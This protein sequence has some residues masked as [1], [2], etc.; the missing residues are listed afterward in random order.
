MLSWFLR[1]R[2]DAFQARY[3][4]DVGYLRE[5]L[6]TSPRVL[7]RFFEAT[8]LG[9][10]RSGVPLE[11][12]TAVHLVGVLHEDCGP[13]VQLGVD[14]ALEAGVAPETLEAILANNLD[15][16]SDECALSV[17]YARAVLAREPYADEHRE[18]LLARYG[19]TGLLSLACALTS[20]RLYP[21]MKYALGFGTACHRV[22]VH[23]PRLTAQHGATVGVA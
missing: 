8:Q 10:V 13:C 5:I 21:T 20:A 14:M 3:D 4:Y 7:L 9:R 11:V 1:R 2:L 15:A 19:G 6:S 12:W 23:T 17:R 16:M 22:T 18:A